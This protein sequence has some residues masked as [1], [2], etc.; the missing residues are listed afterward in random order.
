ML[1]RAGVSEMEH[2]AALKRF[3]N[4]THAELTQIADG[5]D[6]A[7]QDEPRHRSAP[8]HLAA[9]RAKH[10]ENI[11]EKLDVRTRAAAAC[12][13]LLPLGS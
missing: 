13:R 6:R 5:L 11:L 12:A 4:A 7:R 10:V 8:V 2:R 9:H 1:K 3:D